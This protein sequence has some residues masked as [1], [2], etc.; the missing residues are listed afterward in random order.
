MKMQ[1]ILKYPRLQNKFISIHQCVFDT[2][3]L[4]KIRVDE[5]KNTLSQFNR[6]ISLIKL[7][8]MFI[9]FKGVKQLKNHKGRYKV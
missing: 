5:K 4:K 7:I 6:N 8:N 3:L 9:I 1:Q 2:L